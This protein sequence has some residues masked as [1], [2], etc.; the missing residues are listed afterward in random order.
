MSGA[1]D[2][3]GT[4]PTTRAYR[5]SDVGATLY[6]VLGVDPATEVQDGLGRRVRLNGGEPI[7]PLFSG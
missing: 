3:I 2:K 4:Q 1:S 6:T 7:A 5:P